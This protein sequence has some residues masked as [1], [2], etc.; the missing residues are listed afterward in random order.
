MKHIQIR[1]LYGV[2][3]VW[4]FTL[5]SHNVGNYNCCQSGEGGPSK[6]VINLSQSHL[7]IPVQSNYR[8][9]CSVC[10]LLRAKLTRISL[11]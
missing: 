2:L 1:I 11:V 6:K 5:Y 4:F 10:D 3:H 9:C 8:A 7:S